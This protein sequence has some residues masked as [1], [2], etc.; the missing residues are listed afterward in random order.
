MLSFEVAQKMIKNHKFRQLTEGV[1][2]FY[3]FPNSFEVTVENTNNI[4]EVIAI[5]EKA[6]DHQIK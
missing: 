3:G 2:K 1:Q 6:Y 5:L 4:D